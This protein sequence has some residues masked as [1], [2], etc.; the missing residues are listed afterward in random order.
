MDAS[1]VA[2]ADNVSA[3]PATGA[4]LLANSLEINNLLLED[5]RQGYHYPN[6]PHYKTRKRKEKN[7]T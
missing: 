3:E 6:K 7:V 2:G 4:L 5:I 1:G